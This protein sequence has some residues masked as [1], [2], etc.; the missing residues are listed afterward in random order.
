[1]RG[2]AST[3]RLRRGGYTLIELVVSVG[4]FALVMTLASGAYL[5]MIDLNRQ[6][7]GVATGINSL[8]FALENM[9]RSI[10]T[11]TSYNCGVYGNGDCLPNGADTFSFIDS[12][13]AG[14]TYTLDQ[15]GSDIIK[16]IA[17]SS[18]T[19]PLTD[20]SIHISKLT[21]YVSGTASIDNLQPYVTIIVSGTVSSGPRKTPQAFTIQTGATMRG[22]DLT[23]TK[24]I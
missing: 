19:I 15:Q 20:P 6:T 17:P 11:G 14:I 7:Q 9:T 18:D 4:L 16:K 8:S 10:R 12:N 2:P 5:L 22:I 23:A 1:M 3:R 24:I 13:G 21:F